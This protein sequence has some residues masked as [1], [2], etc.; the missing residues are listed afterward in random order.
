M[1]VAV[2]LP[3]FLHAIAPELARVEGALGAGFGQYEPLLLEA[4]GHLFKAGGK[5]MRPILVLLWG[6]A[7]GGIRPGHEILA[8]ALEILH[9]ATLVHDDVIDRAELRRGL[10]SVNHRW[11]ERVSVIAGDFLLAH[12][13]YLIT[14]VG[15]NALTALCALT[16][17]EICDG[18]ILQYQGRYNL[19]LTMERYLHQI[20][21]KTGALLA[22]G[23]EGAALIHGADP[24][25]QAAA[26]EFGMALG[27]CFQ[28]V[29]DLLDFTGDQA[30]VGKPIGHDLHQGFL[31]APVLLALRD[32]AI[33]A[34]LR[35]H[36]L[37]GFEDPDRME[38]AVTLIRDSGALNAARRLAD[39]AAMTARGRLD[40][41]ATGQARVELENLV[42]Y[43]LRRDR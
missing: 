3:P 2:D 13:S 36:L 41:L 43:V 37:A 33:A 21:S 34:D 16:V 26:R 22:C 42:D 32:P 40:A 38:G 20:G 10:A 12:A 24:A 29:D 5:R 8:G 1:A 28:I 18:E 35:R 7:L 15:I 25:V 17:K 30:A 4:G 6:R 14:T 11:D 23:C 9:T 31:T 39:D 27:T 19:G